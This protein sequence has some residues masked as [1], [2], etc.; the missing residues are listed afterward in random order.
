MIH[1]S[2]L[3][4]YLTYLLSI[5]ILHELNG[6]IIRPIHHLHPVDN[7]LRQMQL[8][9]WK[10]IL[11]FHKLFLTTNTERGWKNVNFGIIIINIIL[12]KTWV[13]PIIPTAATD[14]RNEDNHLE[15]WPDEWI[16]HDIKQLEI[17]WLIISYDL[18]HFYIISHNPS[19]NLSQ[20]R[21]KEA[22]PLQP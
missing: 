20:F 7:R 15:H 3:P 18:F 6:F 5:T 12:V 11:S 10:G 16:G 13:T 14:H 22:L 17:C 1:Q 9:C 21:A 8:K 19:T 2:S 4:S